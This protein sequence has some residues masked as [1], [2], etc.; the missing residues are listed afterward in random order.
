MPYSLVDNDYCFVCGKGNPL[1]LSLSFKETHDGV[2]ASFILERQYQGYKG[3]IHGGII[4]AVLDEAMIKAASQKGFNAITAEITIRFKNPLM[5]GEKATVAG[6]VIK[7]SRR[8]ITARATIDKD[9]IIIAEAEGKLY[10]P[11]V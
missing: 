7:K 8:L 9:D 1:G 6:K 2:Y 3:I 11:V 5:I 10:I 4:A